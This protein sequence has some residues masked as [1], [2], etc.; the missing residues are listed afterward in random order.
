MF[1]SERPNKMEDGELN[2]LI[3]GLNNANQSGQLVLTQQIQQ[4]NQQTHFVLSPYPTNTF[5]PTSDSPF[6]TPS[7]S[8]SII[9]R[10]PAP[11][12]SP[13]AHLQNIKSPIPV[14]S[15]GF[16]NVKSPTGSF[17][18]VKS[19][20]G[21]FQNVKSPSL[22]QVKSPGVSNIKSPASGVVKSPANI[23]SP[24][25]CNPQS[26]AQAH[27]PFQHQVV[28]S[29]NSNRSPAPPPPTPSPTAPSPAR[30][31]T[32]QPAVVSVKMD[33]RLGH[34]MRK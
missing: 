3:E 15:P 1:V 28:G 8:P 20:T 34:S 6:P 30:P 11:V 31:N 10:S 25:V 26:P 21:S 29:P 5:L 9:L 7:P 2:S 23:R 12:K 33:T 16:Q 4:Q 18:N 19:P 27:S 32:P 22:Y 13:I 17:Q 24:G 14:K